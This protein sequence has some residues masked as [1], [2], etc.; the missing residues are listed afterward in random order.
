[1][2]GSGRSRILEWGA[3]SSLRLATHVIAPST[4]PI[5]Q[6]RSR[7]DSD[8]T[9]QTVAMR[10]MGSS[11]GTS[12]M[13]GLVLGIRAGSLALYLLLFILEWQH[14]FSEGQMIR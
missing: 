14:I 4:S 2:R 5:A 13:M 6:S 9:H 7:T 12:S 8:R 1:M 3:E 11:I 10:M